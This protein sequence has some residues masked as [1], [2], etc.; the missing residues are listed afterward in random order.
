MHTR[1]GANHVAEAL[2]VVPGRNRHMFV[3]LAFCQEQV[4]A[5]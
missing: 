3:F 5:V 1:G 4:I 2:L